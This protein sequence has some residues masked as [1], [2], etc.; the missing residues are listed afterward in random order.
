MHP[1]V[2]RMAGQIA[3]SL[4]RSKTGQR[5]LVA[6]LV[7]QL[8]ALTIILWLPTYLASVTATSVQRNVI[9]PASNCGPA[10]MPAPTADRSPAPNVTDLTEPQVQAARTIYYTA[11]GVGQR[12]KW[13][14]AKIDRAVLVA[15][16]TAMQESQLGA[17][18]GY[19]RPDENGD[20]G[21]F[22]QRQKLTWYGSLEQVTR[23][24]YAARVFLEGRKVPAA[25]VAAARRA[26]YPPRDINPAGYTLPGLQQTPGWER[27]A[28]TVA[29]QRVQRSAYGGYYAK[30]E[31]IARAA[32]L[33][34][35]SKL[36]PRSAEAR[37][38]GESAL[39]GPADAMSCPTT[40]LGVESGL[41]PDALR[42]VRC[43]KQLSPEI[44]TFGGRQWRDPRD[45]SDHPEGKAVDVMI[46]EYSSPAG[47]AKGNE[48]AAWAVTNRKKLGVKYVIWR[49]RI[50]ST[51]RPEAGWINYCVGARPCDN[52]S[53]RHLNHVH[54]STFGDTAGDDES[55]AA[56]P[57]ATAGPAVLPVATAVLTSRFGQ[58]GQLW[59]RC[60][61]G[62]DFSAGLGTPIRAVLGGRVVSAGWGGPY[63]RLTKI[64][65]RPGEQFWYAHQSVQSVRVGDVVKSGQEIGRVGK[66]GNTTGYHLHLERRVRGSA[67][68]PEEWLRKQGLLGD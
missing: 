25:E 47:I 17:Y 28:L 46:P 5:L 34:F 64:E 68:D 38:V 24:D 41:Q 35:K 8:I 19:E 36:D 14:P 54:V 9:A 62:L 21:V 29:A 13:S 57:G 2:A 43:I 27:D 44:S 45:K 67:V 55:I 16:M 49:E 22:Q 42:V 40:G 26:N 15:L 37:V 11:Q 66:T 31:K 48:I 30:H 20:A 61:T 7:L 53:N 3:L 60:H 18:P 39:C 33:V 59:A 52:D 4:V 32:L 23:V 10:T 56:G 1:T 65:V 58:C 51:T 12:L 6:V 63:G 50:W